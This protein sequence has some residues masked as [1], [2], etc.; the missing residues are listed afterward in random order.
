MLRATIRDQEGKRYVV[1]LPADEAWKVAKG[2]SRLR[3]GPQV[4]ALGVSGLPMN[5]T[6]AILDNL[7]WVRSGS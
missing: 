4:R 1:V 5:E 2:L 6:R 3:K 7:G